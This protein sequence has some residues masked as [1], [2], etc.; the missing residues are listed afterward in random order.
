MPRGGARF[1]HANLLAQDLDFLA[2]EAQ[3]ARTDITSGAMK[4]EQL[5]MRLAQFAEQAE[6]LARSG[7]RHLSAMATVPTGAA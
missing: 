4:T 6:Y 5:L 1:T 7:A 3:I 2:I